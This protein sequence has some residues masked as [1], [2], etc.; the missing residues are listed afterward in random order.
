MG[1]LKNIHPQ[2]S[3]TEEINSPP[4][5]TQFRKLSVD[6]IIKLTRQSPSKSCEHDPVL[7]TIL[8]EVTPSIAPLVASIVNDSMQTGVF[9]QD[10]KEAVVKAVLKKANL[11]LIDK[12]YRPVS[13]LEIMGKTLGHAAT[14]QLTQHISDNNI[15]EAMQSAHRSGHST[16]TTLIKV[17]ANLLCAIDCQEVVCLVLLDLSFGI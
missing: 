7:S 16:E 1:N 9:P 17:K 12:N 3:R 4:S 14:S 2:I 5:F 15:M 11:D 8:K 13:N 10:L 6:D